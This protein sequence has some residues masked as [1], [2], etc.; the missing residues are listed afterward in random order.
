V[1]PTSAAGA[2]SAGL[3]G[4]AGACSLATR[5]AADD[6]GAIRTG[7]DPQVGLELGEDAQ[8]VEKALAGPVPVSIGCSV[9]LRVR[10]TTTPLRGSVVGTKAITA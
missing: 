5:R 9:A 1:R 6:G 2:I 7:E 10:I 3:E 8:H 4:R